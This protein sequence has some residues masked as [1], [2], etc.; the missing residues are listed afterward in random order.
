MKMRRP[1][2]TFRIFDLMS[3]GFQSMKISRAGRS[4]EDLAE[5]P[6]DG[7][8]GTL[9]RGL[10]VLSCVA[11]FGKR[12]ALTKIAR[13]ANLNLA[14]T[15][16]LVMKL[17]ELGYL[18]RDA[19]GLVSLG[20]N[21]LNLGFSYLAS[22]DVRAHALP[23]LER[24]RSDL[25]CTVSLCILD[26]IDIVYVERLPSL[27]PQPSVQRAI[28]SRLPVQITAAGK[29]I[30]AHLPA[31]EQRLI[32]DKIRYGATTPETIRGRTELEKALQ[33]AKRR[34]YAIA[35]RENVH[36]YRA[37]AA[38][39]F[40]HTGHVAAGVVA[41]SVLDRFAS[42]THVREVVAP[43]VVR[44]GQEISRRLGAS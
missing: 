22:L 38:P 8:V 32:L 41:G 13:A 10:H 17:V 37:V 5:Q 18:E 4:P 2:R 34:G 36:G 16:R 44:T 19:G 33:T 42:S 26:G 6:D 21:V 25:D 40:D 30:V 31:A 20:S 24:L 3:T 35:D 9:S 12:T 27:S 14:T 15:Y 28:G 7:P 23:E 1:A 43:R 11:N 39:I 29:V